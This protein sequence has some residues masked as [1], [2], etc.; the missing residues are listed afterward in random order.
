MG[1][2]RKVEFPAVFDAAEPIAFN[3]KGPPPGGGT[4]METLPRARIEVAMSV[5]NVDPH[6]SPLLTIIIE[7]ADGR[8]LSL[9]LDLRDAARLGAILT[10]FAIGEEL[11]RGRDA[12]T[13]HDGDDDGDDDDG[14]DDDDEDYPP[15]LPDEREHVLAQA[16]PGTRE[17]VRRA[18]ADGS[19]TPVA[20]VEVRRRDDAIVGAKATVYDF[21]ESAYRGH[22]GGRF[23][24]AHEIHGIE[25]TPAGSYPIILWSTYREDTT[26]VHAPL[27]A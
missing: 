8:R 12:A 10:S 24:L 20:Y 16:I 14:D 17:M 11:R 5:D 6:G 4:P 21:E 27:E 26:V 2:T 7:E 19:R 9:G 15:L 3:A 23:H 22:E 1:T 13:D 25:A 18:I